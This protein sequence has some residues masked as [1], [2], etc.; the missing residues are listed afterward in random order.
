MRRKKALRSVLLAVMLGWLVGCSSTDVARSPANP[1]PTIRGDVT[2]EKAEQALEM[3]LEKQLQFLAENKDDFK[4]QII[5]LRS[6]GATYYYKYYEDFPEGAENI[7]VSVTPTE[8]F[9]PAFKG[10][11]KYQKIR[12]QTRYTTSE[13]RASAD[14]DF[15]RDEG[16][17]N[18]THEFDG[19]KWNLTSSVFKVTKTSVYRQDRW[20]SSR[21]RLRR[22][23]EEQP[24]L[25]VDRVRNLFGLLD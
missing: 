16:T 1:D 19:T 25:F 11:A 2:Q 22:V 20:R 12:Y 10:E 4:G 23:E 13:S 3:K 8:T 18:E 21:G 7:R 14:D 5:T 6:R 9:N 24:D 15:I 17:Q